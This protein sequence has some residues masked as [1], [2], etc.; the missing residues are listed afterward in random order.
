MEKNKKLWSFK[1]HVIFS[2]IACLI[3]EL[4]LVVSVVVYIRPF[5]NSNEITE[6]IEGPNGLMTTSTR[7][8]LVI[9]VEDAD[10]PTAIYRAGIQLIIITSIAIF[11][12]LLLLYKPMQFVIERYLI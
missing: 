9:G 3:I 1:K 4:C 10:G 2:L 12:M 7:T 8:I 11:L 6:V 5:N